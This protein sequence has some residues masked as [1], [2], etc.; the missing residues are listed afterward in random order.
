MWV[1]YVLDSNALLSLWSV[2]EP[3]KYSAKVKTPLVL[4]V[5]SVAP[6]EISRAQ[7][8][9]LI[10]SSYICDPGLIVGMAGGGHMKWGQIEAQL[11]RRMGRVPLGDYFVIVVRMGAVISS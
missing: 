9:I 4:L 3:I 1:K 5:G 6:D 2:L 7:K 11:G 10:Q 8:S